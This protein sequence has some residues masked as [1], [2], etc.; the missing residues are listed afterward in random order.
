VLIPS[1]DLMGGRIVQLEQ[2]ERLRIETHDIESWIARLSA[3]PLVQVIDL[4]AAKRD[5]SN[6]ALVDRLCR[7]LPCRV[8]GGVRTPE[9]GRRLVEAGARS[10]I[11]GSALFEDGRAR[12]DRAE[13]FAAS[14]GANALVAAI[15]S[16]HGRVVTHGWRTPLTLTPFEA[17]H[18]LEAHVGGFLYTHVDREGLL[19]G[20][21]PA[22]ARALV[23]ATHRRLV[24][25]GG[26]RSLDE[27]ET[28]DR[29]GADAVVGMAIYTGAIDVDDAA[30]RIARG[31]ER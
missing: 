11:V 25:A 31:G 23:A 20:F 30:R 17:M 16:R 19:G 29:L 15:D 24:L 21:D 9:D 6:A 28:L 27:V 5:G 14:I 10:V 22:L 7:A 12:V 8:G 1:I 18:A 13:A 3:F 4:D 2:G 26:I